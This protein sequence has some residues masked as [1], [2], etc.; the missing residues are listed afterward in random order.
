MTKVI[1]HRGFSGKY[2]ENTLIAFRKAIEL[3]VNEIEFDVKLTKDK[4]LIIIHDETVDRTTNG[5]GKVSEMTLEEIKKLN[6]GKKFNKNFLNEKIPTFEETLENIPEE[7]ELNIHAQSQPIVTKKIVSALLNYKRIKTCYMAID[8]TQIS[9]AREI[10]PEV[11]LCN[12]KC[13]SNS[14]EYIEETKKWKCERLQFYTLAYKV[15]KEL[16]KKTHSYGIFVNVFYADTEKEMK[17]YIEYEA[18][19][20]LTNYPDLLISIRNNYEEKK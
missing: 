17:K 20:I 5:K 18:D 11:R 9:L 15:T 7:V 10:C 4:Q 3:K 19:A 16:I 13:Q 12:M 6:A 1:A 8:S 2:P 14:E